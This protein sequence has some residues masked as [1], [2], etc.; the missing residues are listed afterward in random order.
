MYPDTHYFK[1]NNMDCIIIVGQVLALLRGCVW[2]YM[3]DHVPSPALFSADPR[4][5]LMF[6]DGSAARPPLCYTEPMRLVMLYNIQ[7]LGE[8]YRSLFVGS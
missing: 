6:R 1:V 7:H 3:R 2:N 5:G 4:S 8:L